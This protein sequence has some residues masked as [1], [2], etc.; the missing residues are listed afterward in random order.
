MRL[1]ID[2]GYDGQAFSG[3][4]KQPNHPSVQ[5]ALESALATV[6][7]LERAQVKTVV[8]GRTD[9]GVHAV[10]Q[11]CHVD[12][13]DAATDALGDQAELARLIK[14]L[15]GALGKDTHVWIH[16]VS[17]AP[18]GFD[19]RFS[20]V[21][22]RYEYRIADREARHD[23]RLAGHTVWRDEELDMA[24]MNTLGEALLGLHDFA[25]FCR[26]R[27]GATT[28]REL[29][30]FSWLRDDHGVLVGRVVA[31]AF[32]HSM[33]RSLVGSA[34]AVGAGQLSTDDVL[35]LRQEGART[36]A[37]KTMPAH[38]LTLMEIYYPDQEHLATRAEQTRAPRHLPAD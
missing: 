16:D 24:S 31:D 14:R 17:V 27:E 32:C 5:E 6:L 12:L 7:R 23:P 15:R 8:A 36:S 22:R 35:R 3:W 37:W 13:P 34:V 9:A 20:P 2:L 25:A 26:A 29:Q 11:V 33:V 30:E 1:R 18:E 4:A 21:A 19:A 28:I 10:G 38:G